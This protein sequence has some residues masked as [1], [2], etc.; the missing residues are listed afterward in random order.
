MPMNVSEMAGVSNATVAMA[1][2]GSAPREG[3]GVS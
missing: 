1:F 2:Y 3:D